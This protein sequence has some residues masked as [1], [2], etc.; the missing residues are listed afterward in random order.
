MIKRIA[1]LSLLSVGLALAQEPSRNVPLTVPAGTPLRLYLTKRIPRRLNAPVEAKM[2]APLYAF[3]REVVPAGTEV[4]GTVTRLQAVPTGER[5]KAMMSGDFT[6]LHLAEVT[7]TLMRLPDGRQIPIDTVESAELNSLFPSKPPKPRKQS[8]QS[9]KDGTSGAG[10]QIVKDQIDARVSAFKSIPA[11]VQ[12]PGKK[13]KLEDFLWAKLPY[14][15]QFVRVRTRFDAELRGSLDFGST[16]IT[17]SSLALLGSQPSG[18]STVHARLVTPLASKIATQGQT[19]RAVLD[20]PLFSANH[21]LVLPQGTQL[22]GSVVLAKKAGWFHHA[23]R[24]RFTFEGVQLSPETLALL[25]PPAGLPA[26]AEERT[27]QFRTQATLRAAESGGAPVKVDSEGG[28]Q[29]SESKA[30]FFGVALSALVATH[31]GLGDT[32]TNSNGLNTQGRNTGGRVLGGGSG[33][34]LIGSLAAQ[35]S[36]STSL[37]LA[38]Y[39][40]ARSV[41]FGVIARGPEAEFLKNAVVEIG[42]DVRKPVEDTKVNGGSSDS[43]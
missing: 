42:F 13:D 34:G 41:Y 1:G 6:P 33:F 19:V 15:P 7:F 24:L 29:A 4:F 12:G 3:D 5:T 28:V 18:E 32:K 35:L 11:V 22:D 26:P 2:L 25:A 30:R 20:E 14:H 36:S 39:G 8:G 9:Q 40:L 10:T 21:Q 23:G 43:N 16:T 38:Y 27:L 37:G 31:S 17:Q